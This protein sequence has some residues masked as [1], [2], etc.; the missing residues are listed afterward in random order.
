[1]SGFDGVW[2]WAWFESWIELDRAGSMNQG[3]RGKQKREQQM[4]SCLAFIADMTATE[5]GKNPG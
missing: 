5:M 4:Y 3:G 1:M 2:V